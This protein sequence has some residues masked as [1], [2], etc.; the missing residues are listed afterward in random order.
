MRQLTSLVILVLLSATAAAG[1]QPATRAEAFR[2]CYS[3]GEG[4]PA[5][6]RFWSNGLL[7]MTFEL[8]APEPR[9]GS[10]IWS[11][12]TKDSSEVRMVFP[13]P[14]FDLEGFASYEVRRGW[15]SAYDEQA[16]SITYRTL[17]PEHNSIYFS[18]RLFSSEACQYVKSN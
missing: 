16:R 4:E 17:T 2:W 11:Y 8:L 14:E 18:G 10:F 15:A 1:Q 5:E 3:N 9:R 6:L 7:E 12:A 13:D